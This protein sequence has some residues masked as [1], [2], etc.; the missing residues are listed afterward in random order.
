VVWNG[1]DVGGSAKGWADCD[2][3]PECKATL[4]P[5]PGVGHGGTTGLK[6]HGEGPGW[7]G[8]GW[9]WFGWYPDT[10]GTDVSGYNSVTFRIRIDAKSKELAPDPSGSAVA[11]GCSKGKKNSGDGTLAR[12]ARDALDGQWHA[13]KIPLA[14]LMKGKGAE[15][16]PKTAWE[17]RLSTW[18][19]TPRNFDVYL[20][21]IAFEK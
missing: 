11:L 21:D 7:I 10:A 6:F 2:K 3:K 5:T 16:D 8:M 18:S 15:F 13:V 9:N 12:Y 14:H 19:G 17:F 1:E 20:D 4:A